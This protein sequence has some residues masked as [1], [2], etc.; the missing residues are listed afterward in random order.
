MTSRIREYLRG[1][2]PI[3]LIILMGIFALVLFVTCVQ[4]SDEMP[5]AD[6]YSEIGAAIQFKAN[7]CGQ[8]PGYPLLI[9]AHPP[10]YGVRLCSLLIV[11]ADCPFND[12]PP[13]CVELYSEICDVC[14]LPGL[15]P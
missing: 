3:A 6:A 14:D 9:P 12:Y 11:R 1:P 5:L 7:E 2:D 10:E 15:E 4:Q 13:P 8:Q